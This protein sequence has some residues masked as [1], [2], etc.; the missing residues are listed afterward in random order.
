MGACVSTPEG[1]VGV[2]LSSSK[3]ARKRRRG[4]LNR[5]VSS[6]LSKTSSDK[7]ADR[8]SS[9]DRSFTNPTFQGLAFLLSLL[10]MHTLSLSLSFFFFSSN[11]VLS[12]G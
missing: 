11:G 4:G 3:K 2:R 12:G 1:C 5:R 7:T 9:A 8:P 6:R 10:Y